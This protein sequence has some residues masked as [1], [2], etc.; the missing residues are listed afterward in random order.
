MYG[1]GCVT[2]GD[3]EGFTDSCVFVLLLFK[4]SLIEAIVQ[5][6]GSSFHIPVERLCSYGVWNEELNK[7]KLES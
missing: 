6:L 5:H 3:L 4:G 2:G 1:C 7:N